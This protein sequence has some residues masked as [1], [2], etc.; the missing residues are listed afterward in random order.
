MN[1]ILYLVRLYDVRFNVN[2]FRMLCHACMSDALHPAP[3]VAVA[4]LN[5]PITRNDALIYAVPTS[6]HDAG[7]DICGGPP[8]PYSVAY[9]DTSIPIYNSHCL[10]T[11]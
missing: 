1:L 3:S 8:F 2:A 7:C 9:T 6:A 4:S 11:Y 10:P 5:Y